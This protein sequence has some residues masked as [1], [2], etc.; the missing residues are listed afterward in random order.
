MTRLRKGVL[1]V[2]LVACA[3]QSPSALA[4]T[5]SAAPSQPGPVP[6]STEAAPPPPK[7]PRPSP[8]QFRFLPA[9]ES[10]VIGRR[11]QIE[12]IFPPDLPAKVQ[13]SV[14]VAVDGTDV[15]TQITRQPGRLT[16]RPASGLK[17][18]PHTVTLTFPDPASSGGEPIQWSFKVR[19]YG[20]LEEGSLDVE[21]SLTYEQAARR[22][23]GTDPHW[24]LAGNVKISG[25]ASERGV[26]V[27]L[28]GNLRYI[29]AEG[30]GPP[31]PGQTPRNNFDLADFL[32]TVS[33]DPHRFQL[34]DVQVTESFLSTGASFPR[35]GGLLTVDLFGTEVHL[36]SVRSNSIVGFDYGLGIHD[37]DRRVQGASVARDLLPDKALRMK[38]T[39][40]D[41]ENASPQS[42]NTGSAEGGQSGDLFSVSATSS[43]FG[44]TL[45]SEAEVAFSR[46]D[47]NI[48]DEFQRR[49]D[50]GVRVKV[51][52]TLW[53]KLNLG[54]E[55]KRIGL[56]FQ[57]IADPNFVRDREG[58]AVLAD[59]QWG[60]SRYTLGFSQEHD[61]VRDDPLLPRIEQRTYAASWGLQITDY[62]SLTLGY[63]RSEQRSTREPVGFARVDTVTDAFNAGVAYSQ[64]TWSA[65]L[66]SGYSIQD[67]HSGTTP[68][69]TTSWNLTLGAGYRPTP[70]LN[71]AP[72][73]GFTRS[74]NRVTDVAIDTFLPTLTANVAIIPEILVFDSQSSFSRTVAEDNSTKSNSFT[75]IFRLSLSLERFLLNY[76]KQTVS[77]RL[78]YNRTDDEI[79]PVNNRDQWGV[80]F[81]VDLLAPLP[82]LPPGW[83]DPFG[84]RTSGSLQDLRTAFNLRP[85]QY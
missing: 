7:Q 64:P 55:Y 14:V 3:S 34:G 70:N 47:A 76:G 61:N 5:P 75:G 27:T 28:D 83:G 31:G 19:D 79:N 65:N 57:S 4:E 15:T 45:R 74:S 2:V 40:L 78:N 46:F 84:P 41:G 18:G 60:P 16:Y 9:P 69:D 63:N 72:S 21:G 35:R 62:P 36:F 6:P 73:F 56:N 23:Q 25:R 39:Y 37:P 24:N 54:A 67:N 26:A 42:F 66:S 48:A 17:P 11:P 10:V 51:D 71:L 32:F 44:Q 58:G 13:D 59:T 38:V 81:I 29:D 33:K 80:F 8:E 12:A 49:S 68:P 1:L 77:V 43:L 52:G 30:P 85:G 82:L 22:L 53:E 20:A 50:T